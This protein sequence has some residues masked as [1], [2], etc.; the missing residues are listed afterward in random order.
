VDGDL[1]PAEVRGRYLV[2]GLGHCSECH[3]PRNALGGRD[4]ARWLAGGPN[5]DGPGTIPNITPGKLTWSADEIAD[6]LATGF[7]PEYDSAGG[8][9]ADVVGNM[10]RLPPEDRAAIAVPT[11]VLINLPRRLANPAAVYWDK[12]RGRENQVVLAVDT[13]DPERVATFVVRLA[14]SEGRIGHPQHNVIVSASMKPR[15]S[16]RVSGS[17][18]RLAGG[19]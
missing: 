4:M 9:M 17:Y 2:E 7:T 8:S 12:N 14:G 11:D 13:G 18:E 16:L 10:A 5:P 3:T 6:Y 19:V 15:N 1:T